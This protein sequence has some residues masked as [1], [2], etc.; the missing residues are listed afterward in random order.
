MQDDQDEFQ[1]V[2]WLKF[3]ITEII[4]FRLKHMERF[5]TRLHLRFAELYSFIFKFL[6]EKNSYAKVFKNLVR[7]NSENSFVEVLK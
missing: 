7:Y 4:A 2:E 3:V 5:L 1:K 6:H